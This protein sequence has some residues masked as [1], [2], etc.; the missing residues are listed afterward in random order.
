MVLGF[1]GQFCVA[2]LVEAPWLCQDICWILLAHVGI[3]R[4][5]YGGYGDGLTL[6][7]RP[8]IPL[9]NISNAPTLAPFLRDELGGT[10][11]ELD[12]LH[13]AGT[14]PIGGVSVCMSLD[15]VPECSPPQKDES[16]SWEM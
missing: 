15:R 12:L 13:S 2:T 7:L 4:L 10:I 1:R 14:N 5:G 8:P 16:R 6:C 9:A 3:A 11:I